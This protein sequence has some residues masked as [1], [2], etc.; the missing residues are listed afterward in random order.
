MKRSFITSWPGK[1]VILSGL[2]NSTHPLIF[3]SVSGSR[4][5]E[6]F[7]IFF[8]EIKY[9]PIFANNFCDAGQVLI[10]RLFEV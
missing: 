6:N 7:D 3:T 5:T 10:L 2:K 9:F 8:N 1:P 4:A